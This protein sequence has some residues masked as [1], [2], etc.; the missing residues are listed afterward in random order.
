[1]SVRNIFLLFILFIGI[2]CNAAEK[3]YDV[4]SPNG[5]IQLSIS[6]ANSGDMTYQLS[7]DG[8]K[9]I[10]PSRLGFETDGG[11]TLPSKGW[12]IKDIT[13]DKVNSIW[14]PI[15]GKRSTVPEKYNEL[16]L[17]LLTKKT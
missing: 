7:V 5:K 10:A 14:K 17:T 4:K 11:E 8:K 16:T 2:Y 1:M 15:W 3:R 9:V 12:K 13:R 6:K